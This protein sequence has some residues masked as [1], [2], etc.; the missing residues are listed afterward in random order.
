MNIGNLPEIDDVYED[1]E[2]V[3]SQDGVHLAKTK[4]KN[5]GVGGA[6]LR[7]WKED[8]E[9]IYRLVQNDGHKWVDNGKF[10]VAGN[11]EVIIFERE[12]TITDPIETILPDGTH[13][14]RQA[15]VVS[16]RWLFRRLSNKRVLGGLCAWRFWGD[17]TT[18]RLP[19]YDV[20]VDDTP[21]DSRKFY[22]PGWALIS[23][24]KED[25]IY[26]F[27]KV[28]VETGEEEVLQTINP[29]DE[30]EVYEGVEYYVSGHPDPELIE[31]LILRDYKRAEESYALTN[32]KSWT[33]CPW[34][35][36]QTYPS[37]IQGAILTTED[38]EQT[39]DSTEWGIQ[40]AQQYHY[41][42][43]TEGKAYEGTGIFYKRVNGRWEITT[44]NFYRGSVI[45]SGEI[46]AGATIRYM[47]EEEYKKVVTPD[48]NTVYIVTFKRIIDDGKAT[49]KRY[50]HLAPFMVANVDGFGDAPYACISG[51]NDLLARQSWGDCRHETNDIEGYDSL[52]LSELR[53]VSFSKTPDTYN[54]LDMCNTRIVVKPMEDYIWHD[55]EFAWL[56]CV[57]NVWGI[58][59]AG[60]P[61]DVG[62]G[63]D[64]MHYIWHDAGIIHPAYY[65]TAIDIGI[66]TDQYVFYSGEGS[67]TSDPQPSP[68]KANFKV[69][70]Q[71]IVDAAGYL[72]NGKEIEGVET[73][74]VVPVT[75]MGPNPT[76]LASITT[77]AD[78][79]DIYTPTPAFNGLYDQTTGVKIGTFNFKSN[80]TD[81]YA[82]AA[83]G[84]AVEVVSRYLPGV[85]TLGKI[86]TAKMRINGSLYE[87]WAPDTNVRS[88]TYTPSV[89]S[90]TLLGTLKVNGREYGEETTYSIYAPVG[91]TDPNSY[92]GRYIQNTNLNNLS[93]GFNFTF[94]NFTNKNTQTF[95]PNKKQYKVDSTFEIIISGSGDFP[96]GATLLIKLNSVTNI[97]KLEPNISNPSDLTYLGYGPASILLPLKYVDTTSRRINVSS[98]F[99]CSN[100]SAKTVSPILTYNIKVID[101]ETVLYTSM[102]LG[103]SYFTQMN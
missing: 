86:Q 44:K 78:E 50:D 38:G 85:N 11:A 93:T 43:V 29:L 2:V 69:S 64:V 71:G 49:Y 46:P 77:S 40:V 36:K 94:N 63:K 66:G 24:K 13:V 55:D 96:E 79:L 70:R 74:D 23:T 10:G 76:K 91:E 59:Y 37:I 7:Y 42:P 67:D 4:A 1:D 19:S 100:S 65:F 57:D 81:V 95:K 31:S 20:S 80:S 35:W 51:H 90:G 82:P 25:L 47:T 16:Y 8:S 22:L 17:T 32:S 14:H 72:I 62:H 18:S 53:V 97:D 30:P 87:F 60:V 102:T 3:F 28:N 39:W 15:H 54:A 68:Y 33:K 52:P 27:I 88:I 34:A 75:S 101:T 73:I 45:S 21:T 48:P 9:K 83:E 98:S 5:M 92:G 6:G 61:G 58:P 99:I 41:F 12:K 26:Q 56:G 84:G 89:S 103:S